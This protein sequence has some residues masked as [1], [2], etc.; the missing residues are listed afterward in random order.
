MS[1]VSALASLLLAL[2]CAA[3]VWRVADS[4]DSGGVGGGLL[5]ASPLLALALF[6]AFI[7]Y[8]MRRESRAPK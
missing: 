6:F 1:R 8:A 2:L 4:P 5:V 3:I 7:A